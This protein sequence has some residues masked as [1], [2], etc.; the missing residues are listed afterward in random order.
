MTQPLTSVTFRPRA[1]TFP[2]VLVTRP[3]SSQTSHTAV[4]HQAQELSGVVVQDPG[5]AKLVSAV[6]GSRTDALPAEW[7]RAQLAKECGPF[8]SHFHCTSH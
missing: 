2:R 6:L 8:F 3:S 5:F 4:F 7:F 1:M